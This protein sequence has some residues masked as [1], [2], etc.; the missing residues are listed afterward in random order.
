MDLE[1]IR[2]DRERIYTIF[3]DLKDRVQRDLILFSEE[4]E[5]MKEAMIFQKKEKETIDN[6]LKDLQ[7][8]FREVVAEKDQKIQLLSE[9][10]KDHDIR[11]KEGIQVMEKILLEQQ[12][13]N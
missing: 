9:V 12:R 4:R 11:L 7:E 1:S 6:V 5:K 3:F 10:E 2:Q 13:K 8:S